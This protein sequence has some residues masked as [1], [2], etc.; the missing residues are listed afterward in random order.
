MAEVFTHGDAGESLL[1]D[2]QRLEA[3]S[4]GRRQEGVGRA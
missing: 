4:V 3:W 2:V 1:K